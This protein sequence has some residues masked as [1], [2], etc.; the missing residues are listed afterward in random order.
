[1]P[2]FTSVHADEQTEC[3]ARG[4]FCALSIHPSIRKNL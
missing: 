1:M 2:R 4:S 3:A